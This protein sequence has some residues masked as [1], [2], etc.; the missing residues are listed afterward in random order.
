MSR[1]SILI[2]VATGVLLVLLLVLA[3]VEAPA[4]NAELVQNYVMRI[5]GAL[6]ILGPASLHTLLH[7]R[8]ERRATQP[9]PEDE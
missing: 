3:L 6:A 9:P 7:D 4:A 1:R 8:K 2:L 5:E